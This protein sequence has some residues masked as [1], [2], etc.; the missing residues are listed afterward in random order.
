MNIN[1]YSQMFGRPLTPEEIQT[2]QIHSMALG[3]LVNNAVFENEFDSQ[4]FIIDETV[5]ASETKKRFPNLYN[6]NNKLDELA[7]NSFLS[8]Q[9]L[10]IDDLV[11]IID[12]EIRAI[13]FDKLFFEINYPNKIDGILNKHKKQIRNV[14]LIKFNIN[15]F[16]LSN[17]TDLD[18]SINNNKILDF[19]NQNINSYI[20][21]EK[22]DLSYILINKNDFINQ[23]TPTNS[24][25]E[26]YYNNNKNLYLVP[27]KRD[28]IQ[29]NFKNLDDA[30]KFKKNINSLNADEIISFAKDKNIV[31]NNFLKVSDDEVL[32]DLAKVIFS[33]QKNQISDIVETPLAKHI[34]LVSNIYNETQ[35]TIEQS[36]KE[37]SNILL[38]VE[39]SNYILDLKNIISQQILDGL[40]INE[41]ALENS[42]DISIIKNAE[43]LNS[44]LKE[45]LIQSKVVSEGFAINKDF[46]SD[47]I[48]ID[49][50]KSIIINVNKIINKEPFELQE[51]FEDVSKDWIKSLKIK[52]LEEKVYEISSNTKSIKDFSNF[53]DVEINNID[54]TIDS[55]DIASS[56]KNNIFSKDINELLI[57]IIGDEIFVSYVNE[58]SFPE[59]L[60]ESKN[61]LMT[62]ELK[63]SFGA[64]I[65][66][67]KNISTNEN[68]IQ[69][70]ISQY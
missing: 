65:I 46:V 25:I 1:Q 70:L 50:E 28:F 3:T 31:F 35:K 36:R 40:S 41:I 53:V 44:D 38:D 7:L 32:D 59:I 57:T 24:Q 5:L 23:F 14:D 54:I 15:D 29:F 49:N 39:T 68:L 4:K 10:K 51:I 9:N 2:F 42:L 63:S 17:F 43:R 8:K 66:K 52:N 27:E 69:A 22:R 56:F 20:N 67:N 33:L 60:E 61:T 18:I 47:I 13:V 21:P 16:K 55:A 34:V 37:I 48:D 64:E 19:F 30:S 58:V 11:K 6:K 62:S 12:Y 26:N 45:N